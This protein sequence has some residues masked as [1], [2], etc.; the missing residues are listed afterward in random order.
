MI[1]LIT[2]EAAEIIGIITF[3][4]LIGGYLWGFARLIQKLELKPDY[5]DVETMIEKKFE[6]HCPFIDRITN[7]ENDVRDIK[8]W[9]DD[10]VELLHRVEKDIQQVRINT[11]MIC[12][13]LK[14]TYK[15]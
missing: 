15:K 10:R 3:L 12:D 11:E 6:N 9:K 5:K 1:S 14:I 13:E 7:T 4:I 2:L 8:E